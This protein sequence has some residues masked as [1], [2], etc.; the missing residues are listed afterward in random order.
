MSEL[1]TVAIS[2][3]LF[4]RLQKLAA[5]LVDTTDTVI[6]RLLDFWESRL[7]E[8]IV[9][10]N[11]SSTATP[12]LWKSSRGDELLVGKELRGVYRDKTF[13]A[14]VERGGIRFHGKLYDN[15]SPA[16]IAA[17][18]LVGTK[19]KAASTNGRDFWKLQDTTSGQWIPVSA[20]RPSHRINSGELLAELKKIR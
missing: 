14:H 11:S 7:A 2:K 12:A 5:P 18:N 9:P 1:I 3:P 20:L 13:T 6:E 16:A 8:K 17:K 19:G 15:L 10:T 4:E